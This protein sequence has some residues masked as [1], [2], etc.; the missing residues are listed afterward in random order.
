MIDKK[1]K[2]TNKQYSSYSNAVRAVKNYDKKNNCVT[3]FVVNQLDID[4]YEIICITN[5]KKKR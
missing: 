3:K 5:T 2:M 1:H 4:C